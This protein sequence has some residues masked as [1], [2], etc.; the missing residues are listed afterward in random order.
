MSDH[1]AASSQLGDALPVA[2]Q[3]ISPFAYAR[4]PGEFVDDAGDIWVP[5]MVDRTMPDG[6]VVTMTAAEVLEEMYEE[7]RDGGGAL[8]AAERTNADR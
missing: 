3:P 2:D 1:A 7:Q 5:V 8:A 6:R 4:M